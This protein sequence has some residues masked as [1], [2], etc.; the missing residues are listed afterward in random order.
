MRDIAVAALLWLHP[1]MSNGTVEVTGRPSVGI[2]HTFP[3]HNERVEVALGTGYQAIRGRY[4]IP[5]Q[6][7]YLGATITVERVLTDVVRQY[8]RVTCPISERYPLFLT[9]EYESQTNFRRERGPY[10]AGTDWV[11]GYA[12]MVWSQQDRY[13]LTWAGRNVIARLG[14][15]KRS[16][17][18]FTLSATF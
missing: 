8:Y 11:T 7:E 3:L 17:V 10:S 18:A 12:R 1:M 2:R 14:T 13:Y 4:M 16:V 15:D 6:G 5:P 9:V